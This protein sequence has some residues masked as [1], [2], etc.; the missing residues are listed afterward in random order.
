MCKTQEK[1]ETQHYHNYKIANALV[2]FLL[3]FLFVHTYPLLDFG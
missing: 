1:K 2:N 3:V